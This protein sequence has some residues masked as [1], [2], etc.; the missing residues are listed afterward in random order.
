MICEKCGKAVPDGQKFC[1]ECGS[2][3]TQVM[4]Q[5]PKKSP[6]AKN[7]QT[8]TLSTDE[9]IPQQQIL[10]QSQQIEGSPLSEPVQ[11]ETQQPVSSPFA[12]PPSQSAFQQPASSP[13]APPPSQGA[14]RQ[15]AD[16]P[17]AQPI[18]PV[19]QK[20]DYQQP[21]YQQQPIANSTITSTNDKGKKRHG[22]SVIALILAISALLL[23]LVKGLNVLLALPA[24]ILSI[25]ALAKKNNDKVRAMV[26]LCIA[27]PAFLF[28]CIRNSS[29]T[30]KADNTTDTT[31]ASVVVEV[32]TQN[33]T[34]TTESTP[35]IDPIVG[36]KTSF[37]DLGI[38]GIGKKDGIYVGLQ[39]VRTSAN[40]PTRLGSEDVESGN[41]VILAFFEFY[42]G[43][44][45]T[46]SVDPSKITCY[47][48]GTQVN[49]VESYIKV[50]ADGVA[51]YYNEDLDAGCQ[52]LSVQDFE[53]PSEWTEI[54]FFYKSDCVWT[55]TQSDIGESEYERTTLFNIDNSQE[56][57][58]EDEIIF[59]DGYEVQYKGIEIYHY[60]RS[61]GDEDYVIVKF[62]ITNNG[63]GPL[64]TSLMG[65]KM[66]CYQNNYY[67]GDASFTINKTISNFVDIHDIDSIEAGMSADVYLAFETTTGT[68]G[69]F[70]MIYDDGY[71]SSHYC[72]SVYDIINEDEE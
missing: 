7:Y 37:K 14:F 29:K 11:A 66:R 48:D 26:A 10:N 24:I 51:Q 5:E 12:P 52:L 69:S 21:V 63:D 56:I 49:D 38:G 23:F 40:L 59:S 3:I 1:G 9:T 15:P 25:I 70:Y 4:M 58:K 47:V 64:D 43:T 6:F 36:D 28:G 8:E 19:Y 61:Y 33:A 18:Q 44:D 62:H 54:K 30:K 13:F 39:Y 45:K 71:I 72:G 68:T 57:T 41:T 34:E 20:I 35:A 60:E 50:Y 27:I 22:L 46:Q 65:Y 42:N 2:P 55:I 17:N 67:L 53:V 16:L 32:D 31:Q